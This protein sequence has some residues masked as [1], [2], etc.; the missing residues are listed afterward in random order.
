MIEECEA[1]VDLATL[2]SKHLCVE[3]I[4]SPSFWLVW[5]NSRAL[6]PLK[7]EARIHSDRLYVEIRE[8]F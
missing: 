6:S 4:Q 1:T 7:L 5:R 2:K 8:V 3:L